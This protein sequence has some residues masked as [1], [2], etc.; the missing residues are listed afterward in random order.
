MEEDKFHETQTN[1]NDSNSAT[2]SISVNSQKFKFDIDHFLQKYVDSKKSR[3]RSRAEKRFFEELGA[4]LK[5]LK[6]RHMTLEEEMNIQIKN[7]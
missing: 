1:K 6:E 3:A 2:E 4:I 5:G 7:F